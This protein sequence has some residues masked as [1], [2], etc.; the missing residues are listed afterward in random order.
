MTSI[1]SIT[2]A[3]LMGLMLSTL[4]PVALAETATSPDVEQLMTQ[5]KATLIKVQSE[6][7]AQKL[8]P[9]KSVQLSLQTGIRTTAGGKI[10]FFVISLG[11]TVSSE[12]AQTF[13]LTLKPPETKSLSAFPP[14]GFSK[15]LAGA[16]IS[17][18]ETIARSSTQK[19]VLTLTNLSASIKFVSETNIEG[20]IAKV[21]LLPISIDLG[22]KITPT[23][24]HEV[25]LEFGSTEGRGDR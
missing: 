1:R 20:G 5:V 15:E 21:Q 13:K 17:V 9:L 2:G 18:A 4:G 14:T 23:N 3:V 11:D 12:K 6:I 8:P 16:I 10:V 25:I 19:P 7:T 22:G 24:T